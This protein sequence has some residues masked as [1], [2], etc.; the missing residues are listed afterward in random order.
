MQSNPR[1]EPSASCMTKALSLGRVLKKA[2]SPTGGGS[3]LT[4]PGL[5]TGGLSCGKLLTGESRVG[6]PTLWSIH[7]VRRRDDLVRQLLTGG[8]IRLTP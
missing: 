7:S 8:F 1:P 6:P 4:R 2:A 5:T 3:I